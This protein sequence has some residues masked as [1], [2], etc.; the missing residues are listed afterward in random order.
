MMW[1][2]DVAT[3]G[4]FVIRTFSTDPATWSDLCGAILA[5]FEEEVHFIIDPALDGIAQEE[6]LQQLPTKS[7]HSFVFI[8]DEATYGSIE[9]SLLV[10][11]LWEEPGRT[12]RV[13][14]SQ[15]P[16]VHANLWLANM[17]FTEFAESVDLDGV[18]RGFAQ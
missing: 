3:P 17:D 8:A 15:M 16:D 18:F 13:V 10:L 14:L 6:L 12:F 9:R 7:C 11:D 1:L 2:P 4:P 5:E